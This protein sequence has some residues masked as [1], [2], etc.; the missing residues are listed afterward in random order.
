MEMEQGRPASEKMMMERKRKRGRRKP[1]DGK[2]I[3]K[4]SVS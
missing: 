1:D 4:R 3:E 2:E